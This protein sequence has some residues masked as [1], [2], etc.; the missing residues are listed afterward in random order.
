MKTKVLNNEKSGEKNIS[1]RLRG[2]RLFYWGILA[3]PILQFIVFYL[4]VNIDGFVLAFQQYD[5]DSKIYSFGTDPLVNFK[6]FFSDIAASDEVLVGMMRSFM[7]YCFGFFVST[8]I[9]LYLSYVLYKRVPGDHFF[10]I[11]LYVPT[12]ISSTVWV[13]LYTQLMENAVPAIMQII[14]GK[15]IGGVISNVDT[16]FPAILYFGKLWYSLG[17][18]TLLYIANMNG[19]PEERSE[20]MKIDGAGSIREFIHLTFPSLWPIYSLGL[21]TGIMGIITSDVGLY[22]FFGA[23]AP[24]QLRTFG[25]WLTV[26]K[27][28][29]ASNIFDLP[30][31]AAIGMLQGAIFIPLM[32]IVRKALQKFGPSED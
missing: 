13:L 25:Y 2:D 24:A 31:V 12:I 17:G 3:W 10:K 7:L 20:A 21:Y 1:Q 9:V 27:F 18:G 32:F 22:T 5:V 29:A 6:R 11:M 15:R 4:Y 19:I 23:S 14:T 16:S 8:P 26:R 28:R 30:Y